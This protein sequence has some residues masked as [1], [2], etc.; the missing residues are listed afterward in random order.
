MT[1]DLDGPWNPTNAYVV[2]KLGTQKEK[3][4]VVGGKLDPKFNAET[5]TFL[6][7]VIEIF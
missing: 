6:F 5:T 4:K 1:I 2:V 3:T 7:H